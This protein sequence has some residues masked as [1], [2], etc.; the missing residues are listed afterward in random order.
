MKISI[1]F[2]TRPEIIKLSMLSKKLA[3]KHD[4][5]N[6]FTGQHFSLFND[7]SHMIPVIDCK[8][9]ITENA[10]ITKTYAEI[11]DQIGR[12]LCEANPDLVMVQGDTASAYSAA[13]CAF[14]MGIKVG[15]VE[16]GLR[17]YN[18]SSPFPEEFNRQMISKIAYY[19]WCP[20][21]N[22]INNLLKENVSGKIILTGNTIVDFVNS[23]S[24]T[25][26]LEK[27]IIITLHRREN[28][29]KFPA[30]LSQLNQM[31]EIYSDYRF[32]FPA[33]PNPIIQKQL[34]LVNSANIEITKPM[35]YEQ[36]IQKLSICS[37]VITDSG[38]IQEEAICLK[39]KVL[40]CRNNTERPEGIDLGV[41]KLVDDNVRDNFEWLIS[42]LDKN[43]QNPYGNG[44]A[45]DKIIESL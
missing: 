39:K 15:H 2:G 13:L 16:A 18:I 26:Q 14:L 30:I 36:F 11:Q 44:D 19:N 31:A 29:D 37:G 25:D 43:F 27:S 23:I 32:I 5:K 10:N 20:S 4:V 6:V 21:K 40:V 42:P 17:T 41:C 45:C 12:Y 24:F 33:H 3:Q 38:G 1:F 34:Y 8:L 7:V 35:T 9:T 22:S 28:K